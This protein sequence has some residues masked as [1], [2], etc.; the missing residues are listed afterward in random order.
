LSGT[1]FHGENFSNLGGASPGFA[2][3]S[4]GM[5][6][7]V[8]GSAGWV[9]LAFPVTRRLTFDIYG[10]RQWNNAGDLN[11]YGLARTFTY[12]GNA[13]YRIAPNIVLGFEVSQSRLD[14]I[15][16]HQ[17]LSNRY[18]ATVAYLF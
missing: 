16:I 3:N 18:D 10:G 14:F 12:A 13:L 4:T 9:Q 11:D 2:Y 15:D 6:I 5:V 1:V 7:P 8:R 17:A